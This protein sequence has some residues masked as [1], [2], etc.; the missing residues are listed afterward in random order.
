MILIYGGA[1]TAPKPQRR[2]RKIAMTPEEV[3]AFLDAERTC[4]VATNGTNG[5]HATPLWYLWEPSGD[6][7]ALW[8]TSLS[9]SQRWADLERDPRIAVVVD[10]GHDYGELRG[11]ELRGSV[12]IVGEVPRTGEPHP[13]LERVEQAFADRYSGGHVLID[14]RHAWLRLRPEKITSWDFRKIAQG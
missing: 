7:G 14:G 1:V 11:V 8:L 4:R 5:P 6:T 10:A 13:E 2:A 12:E 9:R 3:A